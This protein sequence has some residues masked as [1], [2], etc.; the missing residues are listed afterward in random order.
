MIVLSNPIDIVVDLQTNLIVRKKMKKIMQATMIILDKNIG[1]YLLEVEVEVLSFLVKV[2][3][4][5]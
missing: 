5:L 2:A 3:Y 1:R 4:S